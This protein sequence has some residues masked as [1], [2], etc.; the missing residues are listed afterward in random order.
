MLGVMQF[1]VV[2]QFSVAIT[3]ICIH[4]CVIQGFLTKLL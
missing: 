1:R 4:R 2:R 3:G